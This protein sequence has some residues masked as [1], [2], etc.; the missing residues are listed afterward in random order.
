MRTK[1]ELFPKS[2]SLAD[3]SAKPVVRRMVVRRPNRR[4]VGQ[5]QH[6]GRIHADLDPAHLDVALPARRT[7]LAGHPVHV[8]SRVQVVRKLRVP[9][10][11]PAT[12]LLLIRRVRDRDPMGPFPAGHREDREED[13]IQIG[14]HAGGLP[15][16]V[17]NQVHD[18]GNRPR[19]HR[20]GY[21][22]GEHRVDHR[23]QPH[24][25]LDRLLV[26]HGAR[27]HAVVG[28]GVADRD[29]GHSREHG[30]RGLPHGAERHGLRAGDENQSDVRALDPSEAGRSGDDV[31]R[32]RLH[33]VQSGVH[34]VRSHR[35]GSRTR[36][37]GDGEVAQ[38]GDDL[39]HH[40]EEGN[41]LGV[42][43]IH[44]RDP[45]VDR[46]RGDVDQNGGH[47]HDYLVRDGD[48]STIHV[49]G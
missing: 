10:F 4:I 3:R 32:I 15:Q 33:D 6:E 8:R 17:S 14:C 34:P 38:V 25:M 21:G 27:F 35:D 11:H 46:S 18:D 41:G 24:S 5:N 42:H 30:D 13:Q 31:V 19:V 9:G 48:D 45:G 20:D 47:A 44:P 23:G 29:E 36:N 16:F 2:F 22:P 40:G 1:G 43:R 12:V 7:A 37:P 49:A 39:P 26:G 28:S